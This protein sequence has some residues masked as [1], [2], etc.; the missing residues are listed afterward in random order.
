[1]GNVATKKEG[2]AFRY[3]VVM[4]TKAGKRGRSLH[5]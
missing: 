4:A 3:S 1:M 5:V 2:G